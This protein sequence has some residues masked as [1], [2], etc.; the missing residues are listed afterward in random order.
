[1]TVEAGKFNDVW[2]EAANA[3]LKEEDLLSAIVRLAS[4]P[5]AMPEEAVA[6]VSGLPEGEGLELFERLASAWVPPLRRLHLANLI[7]RSSSGSDAALEIA[8]KVLAKLYDR[9]TRAK[10]TMRSNHD[11]VPRLVQT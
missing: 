5:V 9:D 8:Q 11:R 4:V 10:D 1:M 7:L 3:L 6:A 2:M